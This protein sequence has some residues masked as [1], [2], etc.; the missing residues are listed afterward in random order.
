MMAGTTEK[1]AKIHYDALNDVMYLSFGE[2]QEA[3][4]EEVGDGVVMRVNPS[5]GATVGFTISDFT[6]R[7]KR[8]PEVSISV[9]LEE[10]AHA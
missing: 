4:G 6:A 8:E 3:L 2:P 1:T 10:L 5:T 7:F 9:S